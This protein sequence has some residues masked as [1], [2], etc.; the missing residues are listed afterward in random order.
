M[1]L[2][3]Y[4]K[5]LIFLLK[6]LMKK[7]ILTTSLFALFTGAVIAQNVEELWAIEAGS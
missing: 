2:A 5:E 7:I 6:K 4:Y 3:I 1:L